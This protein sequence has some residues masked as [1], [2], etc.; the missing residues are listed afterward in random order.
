MKTHDQDNVQI[1]RGTAIAQATDGATALVSVGFTA[2]EVQRLLASVMEGMVQ[3]PSASTTMVLAIPQLNLE[4]PVRPE[5]VLK[6]IALESQIEAAF[7]SLKP[8][9]LRGD[10]GSGGTELSRSV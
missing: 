5:P 10:V 9:S 2:A 1:A 4:G 6:R 3:G 8:V 7:L